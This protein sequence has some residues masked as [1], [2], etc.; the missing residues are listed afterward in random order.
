MW[1]PLAWI[2]CSV[3]YALLSFLEPPQFITGNYLPVEGHPALESPAPVAKAVVRK[4]STTPAVVE[5]A[6]GMQFVLLSDNE[7]LFHVNALL[8]DTLFLLLLDT[9]SPYTWVYGPNCTAST[10]TLHQVYSSTANS[11][12]NA[13][14]VEPLLFE[15]A[16][17]SDT[18]SGIVVEDT[19]HLNSLALEQFR[20]GLASEAPAFLTDYPVSG[21][22]GLPANSTNYPNITNVVDLLADATPPAI[23]KLLFSILLGLLTGTDTT[24]NGVFVLGDVVDGLYTGTLL[25]TSVIPNNHLYWLVAVDETSVGGAVLAFGEAMDVNGTNTTTGRVAIVDLG[26]TALVMPPADAVVYHQQFPNYVLDGTNYA[27]YCNSTVEVAL[28]IGGVAW[29]L[30]SSQYLG[31]AYPALLQ[32]YGYCVSNVQALEVTSNSLWILG[33]V[34]LKTVYA[35][36]DL[37]QQLLGLAERNPL[38]LFT[39]AST[40]LVNAAV[41]TAPSTALYTGGHTLVTVTAASNSSSS[42]RTSTAPGTGASFGPP[43][44]VLAL[45][46]LLMW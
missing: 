37:E 2:A 35:V 31:T 16:Y 11:A 14:T 22:V 15:L 24:N 25:Y 30:D 21:V 38:V 1:F 45:A 32:Y 34:F 17:G 20:F 36:F 42:A 39:T 29:T 6:A 7:E 3:T 33:G 41:S 5:W 12:H 18:A 28:S 8:G 23:R 44:I 46:A 10:C 9:G 4:S 19:L 40:T 27:V 13:T 26:T 43:S